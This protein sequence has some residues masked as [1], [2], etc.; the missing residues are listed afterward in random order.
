M[1]HGPP[2][3][4]RT[5]RLDVRRKVKLLIPTKYHAPLIITLA[6]I[7]IFGGLYWFHSNYRCVAYHT[8]WRETCYTYSN[9]LSCTSRAVEVC[10]YYEPRH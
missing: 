6:A 2:P 1:R 9:H 4:P 5:P 3:H 10:D 8:E 7:V